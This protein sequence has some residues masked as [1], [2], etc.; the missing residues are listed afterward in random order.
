MKSYSSDRGSSERCP[1]H[2]CIQELLQPPRVVRPGRHHGV[3]ACGFALWRSS[4]FLHSR[5]I[6]TQNCNPDRCLDLDDRRSV[7]FSSLSLK[8]GTGSDSILGFRQARRMWLICVSAV[9]WAASPLASAPQSS[10]STNPKL[11]ARR[12]VVAWCLC[13]SGLSRG[14]Y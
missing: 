13:S 3:N 5:P 11:L 8:L 2:Q 7:S 1:G 14:A 9:L 6:L 12:F 10:L 4:I